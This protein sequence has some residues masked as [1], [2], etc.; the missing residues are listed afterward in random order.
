MEQQVQRIN[1]TLDSVGTHIKEGL[2]NNTNLMDRQVQN[3]SEKMNE[4]TTQIQRELE[5]EEKLIE[6]QLGHVNETLSSVGNQI[7]QDLGDKTAQLDVQINKVV[8]VVGTVVETVKTELDHEN[9]IIEQQVHRV[10]SAL[11]TT[12]S[13]ISRELEQ[14]V[15]QIE[16][17]MSEVSKSLFGVKD[18]VSTSEKDRQ[19]QFSTLTK[20]IEILSETSKQLQ[21]VLA[22]NRSRGQWGERIADDLL[23][24]AGFIEGVNY[25]RQVSIEDEDGKKSRPDFTFILPDQ[26]TVNMDVKF[27]LDNYLRYMSSVISDEKDGYKNQFLV[28]I[29]S[30]VREIEKRGYINEDQKNIDLMLLFIPSEQI[31]RFVYEEDSSVFDEALQKRIIICSPLTLFIILSIIRKTSEMLKVQESAREI[32]SLMSEFK[33]QWGKYKEKMSTVDKNLKTAIKAFD[34]LNTARERSLDKSIE[35]IDLLTKNEKMS[36]DNLPLSTDMNVEI[37][38]E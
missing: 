8:E 14:R 17:K 24:L 26:K 28:D 33:K 36:A 15:A 9:K 2:N 11:E 4:V 1:E 13:K 19:S 35:K 31:L 6:R 18:I 12:T 38:P 37:Q 3:I 25:K 32:L 30:R 20:Q 27:P 22:D 10:E 16:E 21:M 23:K 34:E 7:K 29:R 5:N